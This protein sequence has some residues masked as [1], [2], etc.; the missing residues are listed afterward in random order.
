[1][2]KIKP[3]SLFDNSKWFT[4]GHILGDGSCFYH[5][6]LYSLSK[7]YRNSQNTMRVS[8]AH[9]FRK[10]IHEYFTHSIWSKYYSNFSSYAA[11]RNSILFEWAG[12]IEWQIV[13]DYLHIK[14]VIF[15]ET[16][17]SLYW[18]FDENNDSIQNDKRV[19]F[20]LNTNDSH[21]EPIIYNKSSGYQHIFHMNY[22]I[23]NL[24]K[25]IKCRN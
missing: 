24:L 19:L 1:M 13:S 23:Y 16:D 15:R 25:K 21:F 20:I 17:Q 8:M 12:N 9:S 10:S 22:S 2:P 7:T 14:I 4:Y 11:I 3:L 6:V 5:S 18:G